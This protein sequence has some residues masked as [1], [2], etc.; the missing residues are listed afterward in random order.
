MDGRDICEYVLPDAQVKIFLT[1][2]VDSRARR[3]YDELT[4]KGIECD[5]EKI[6]ADM[7]YRDKNDSTRAVSPLKQAA[8]ATLVDTTDLTFEQAVEK[9]KE[10]IKNV[11]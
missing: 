8:D 3:R 4:A 9:V 2:S 11:L 1:A 6:K 7:E 5:F 10:L